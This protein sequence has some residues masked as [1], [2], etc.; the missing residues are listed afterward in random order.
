MAH[1]AQID[2]EKF[3]KICGRADDLYKTILGCCQR[4]TPETYIKQFF[5]KVVAPLA[6]P[7]VEGYE[8]EEDD[9]ENKATDSGFRSVEGKLF[10]QLSFL[11]RI[12]IVNN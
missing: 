3:Q 2:E 6:G 4:W 1:Y 8:I 11:V 5:H 7:H 9:D 12:M 10:R